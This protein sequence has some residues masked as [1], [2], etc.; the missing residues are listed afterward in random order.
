[1]EGGNQQS[2]LS[3]SPRMMLYRGHSLIDDMR[4]SLF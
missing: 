4:G 1:M 2:K 3:N